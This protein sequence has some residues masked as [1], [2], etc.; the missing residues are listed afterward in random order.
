[1]S[2]KRIY[3]A[4]ATLS[5][6]EQQW[7]GQVFCLSGAIDELIAHAFGGD[8]LPDHISIG[9]ITPVGVHEVVCGHDDCAASLLAWHLATLTPLGTNGAMPA[10]QSRDTPSK[11]IFWIRQRRAL[12]QGGFYALSLPKHALKSAPLMMTVDQQST[13]LWTCEEVAK[14]GQVSTVIIETTD[15]DLTTARRLQLACESGG[16]R[17]IVMRP[18]PRNGHLSPSSAWTR[19]QITPQRQLQLN[20][21]T[22]PT[23]NDHHL[24]LIGGRGVRPGSWKVKTDAATF[25]LSVADPLENRLS[26]DQPIHA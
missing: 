26:Q 8:F 6:A 20:R 10:Q 7:K 17:I 18:A 2:N 5:R 23:G 11:N 16:T 12:D 15:Y 4:R 13:A 21:Q 22:I 24:S 19:W 14:S 9:G 3:Q 1:M 25:S